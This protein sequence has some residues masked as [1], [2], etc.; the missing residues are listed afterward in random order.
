VQFSRA[1]PL[2]EQWVVLR[3]EMG[4]PVPPRYDE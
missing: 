1:D 3:K 4:L 2:I